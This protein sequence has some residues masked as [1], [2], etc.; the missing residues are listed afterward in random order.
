MSILKRLI[1]IVA[2]VVV[3][4][5]NVFLYWNQ[6][7]YN[8]A[9]KIGDTE[10]RIE[11]L[12]K[13][14]KF[15]P[16]NDLVFYELGKAYH[17]LGMNSLGE[18][19]RSIVHLQK[20]I[21]HFNR[22]LRINPTSYFGHFYLAQSL[23]NMSFD[24]PS[25]EDKAHA[26]YKKATDL[27]G[28]N[29]EIFFEVGKNFLSRWQNLSQEDKDFTLEILKKVVDG[30]DRERIQSLFYLWEINVNDY[31]VM[32]KILP[33]DPQIY[34]DYTRFLG[35]KSLSLEDRQK[36]LAKAEYLEF[37]RAKDVFD[38][39]EYA[40]FYYRLKEAQNHFRSC[41]N[42]LEKIHFYQDLLAT[43]NQIDPSEFDGL[44]KL[45]LLNLVKSLLEQG[46][47]LKDVEGY[48]W[49]YLAREDSAAAISELE[50]FLKGKGLD[51]G[52][53]ESSFNDLGRLS[54][55]LYF[56]LKQGRFRDNMRVGRNL[57]QSFV[58]VPEGKEYQFVK[59][60]QIV[61]ESFQ[62]VDY[63]YDSNDFYKRALEMA[64]EN[65]EILVRLRRNY[66]RLRAD[67][68]I[69]DV[70]R[71]IGEIISPQE[72]SVNRSIYR[73]QTFRR[74]MVLDGRSISL[75]LHFGER[76]GDRSPL[77]T[78]LYNGRV[79]WEDYLEE[80]VVSVPVESKVG[81]NVIQVV[82][83]NWGVELVRIT[84]E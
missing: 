8:Q 39:G 57:L 65:L 63:I 70:S 59:I 35:E 30:R 32:E 47:E 51:G 79:V 23:F 56:S 55:R 27:A 44:Q 75:G 76:E 9:E 5:V 71:K 43:Q 26:Q 22:S 2:I 38:A 7:L 16:L 50:S 82:P 31:E 4:A 33:E 24:S 17:D 84:Y 60:L 49:E 15:N 83:V 68:K 28:Q 18:E 3:A 46:Q 74:S 12:E 10:K 62:K 41:L 66:E 64:P 81:E 42:I 20:S 54:F 61:G 80:D 72:I 36:Y 21:S 6:H 19:G 13:A 25:Q 40:L 67:R 69:E 11:V 48:L 58:V 73:G 34:R 37:Q 52:T 29:S 14:S 77:V 45:A 1:L 78:V 53:I